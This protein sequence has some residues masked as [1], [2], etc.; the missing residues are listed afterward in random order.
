ME[1]LSL[2]RCNILHCDG[3]SFLLLL[4]NINEVNSYIDKLQ[5][6]F[7]QWLLDNF[8]TQ[9][10]LSIGSDACSA[11]DLKESNN[12]KNSFASAFFEMTANNFSAYDNSTLEEL[13]SFNGQYNMILDGR[14][15][16]SI[17]HTSSVQLMPYDNDKAMICP[18][19]FNL[20]KLGEAILDD[21]FKLT[22]TDKKSINTIEVFSYDKPCYLSV[23][24][25]KLEPE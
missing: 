18:T 2:S 5:K 10:Y 22:I 7:N 3:G 1:Q 13:F 24:N 6:K 8:G 16:C 4:P 25:D 14:K 17:C 9:L 21:N 20:Y 19:C 23:I 11:N 12:Q 15:E